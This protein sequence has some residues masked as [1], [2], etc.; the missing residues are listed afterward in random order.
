MGTKARCP[1][2]GLPSPLHSPSLPPDPC[3][4]GARPIRHYNCGAVKA[5]LQLPSRMPGLVNCWIADIREARNQ[6]MILL[7]PLCVRAVRV[8]KV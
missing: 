4:A 5:A 8:C 7:V 6:V 1:C 2:P 3:P